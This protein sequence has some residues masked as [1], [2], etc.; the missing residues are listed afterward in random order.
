MCMILR[1]KHGVEHYEFNLKEHLSY[2]R[3]KIYQEET[4]LYLRS[5]PVEGG[6]ASLDAQYQGTSSTRCRWPGLIV[7]K[8]RVRVHNESL[9]GLHSIVKREPL[10]EKRTKARACST[11]N[12]A[13]FMMQSRHISTISLPTVI[14]EMKVRQNHQ[15]H[16]NFA[17]ITHKGPHHLFSLYCIL[18]F[19]TTHTQHHYNLSNIIRR[20]Y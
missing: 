15:Q 4:W 18:Y 3:E 12:N 20:E 13:S 19:M 17:I 5:N 7:L 2:M 10:I 6:V 14:T 8:K 1:Q 9:L 16:N 11:S